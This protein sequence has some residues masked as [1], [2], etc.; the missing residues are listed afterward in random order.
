MMWLYDRE[1]VRDDADHVR[2]QN[3]HEDRVHQRKELH[4]LLA[5]GR[6]DHGGYKHV[7]QFSGRLGSGR[8]PALAF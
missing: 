5:G 2:D 7:S 1:E 8:A 6:A 4:A 3:E